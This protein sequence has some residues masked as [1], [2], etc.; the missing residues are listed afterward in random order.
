MRFPSIH[1]H[2]G[3]VGEGIVPITNAKNA[4]SASDFEKDVAVGMSVGD[5][6]PVDIEQNGATEPSLHDPFAYGHGMSL[7]AVPCVFSI[8]CGQRAF[9]N[10]FYPTVGF[11]VRPRLG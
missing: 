6:W 4:I 8:R 10:R 11:F 1:D 9:T 5:H 7:G 2:S 3:I